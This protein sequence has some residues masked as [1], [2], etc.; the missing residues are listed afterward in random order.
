MLLFFLIRHE[1][2]VDLKELKENRRKFC[3]KTFVTKKAN[4]ILYMQSNGIL[5]YRE[6]TPTQRRRRRILT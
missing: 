6:S 5:V 1:D 2:D 4:G 3:D